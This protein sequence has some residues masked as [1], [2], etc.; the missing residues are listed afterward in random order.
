MVGRAHHGGLQVTLGCRSSVRPP[1]S[2]NSDDRGSSTSWRVTSRAF[3]PFIRQLARLLGIR[4]ISPCP[5]PL[6]SVTL[7]R[8]EES[9]PE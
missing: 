8:P 3:A 5:E 1:N 2:A 6:T 7:R 4:N 9:P